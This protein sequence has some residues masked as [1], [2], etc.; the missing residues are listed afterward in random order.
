MLSPVA[1]AAVSSGPQSLRF[2]VQGFEFKVSHGASCRIYL[3]T[4]NPRNLALFKQRAWL[5][6]SERIA[7]DDRNAH[8]SV[9]VT[10]RAMVQSNVSS[11]GE[12]L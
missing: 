8:A 1:F 7:P 12:F 2:R 4:S 6:E 11:D 5:A 10:R 3:P 9:T